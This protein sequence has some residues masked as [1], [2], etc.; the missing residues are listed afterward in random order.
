MIDLTGRVA[1]VFGAGA[2]VGRATALTMARLGA[3]V[4]AA[5]RDPLAVAGTAVL[6]EQDGQIQDYVVDIAD[7]AVSEATGRTSSATSASRTSWCRRTAGTAPS[8][9]PTTGGLTRLG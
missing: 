7:R 3:R 9:S 6:C 1:V 2:G 4:A 8:R 5:D